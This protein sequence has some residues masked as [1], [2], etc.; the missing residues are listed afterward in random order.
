MSQKVGTPGTPGSFDIGNVPVLSWDASGNVS[1]LG[2]AI[3]PLQ[4]IT[5]DG[6]IV[7]PATGMGVV[8]LTKGS[9][10]AITIAAPT[11]V[12][13]DGK[14]IFVKSTTAFAH[15]ITS[16]V[17]GFNAKGSSGTATAA[18]PFTGLL[19]L[20]ASNGHW[21]TLGQNLWTIA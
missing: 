17:D 18:T 6:A 5:G 13:D 11:A 12:V 14:T 9:A 7:L 4:T 20:Y 10:A 16:A 3:I 15:V 1:L 2:G 21:Y 8:L 19:H